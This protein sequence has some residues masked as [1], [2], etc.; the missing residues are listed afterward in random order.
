MTKPTRP[1]TLRLS[2]T[3]HDKY[4]WLSFSG[5]LSDDMTAP[6]RRRF[7][8][9]LWL[10]AWPAPLRVVIS[11]D[12]SGSWD[13]AEDWAGTWSVLR[14]DLELRFTGREVPRGR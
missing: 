6:R 9:L 5:L 10:L 13:W 11:A 4:L 14:G 7:L 2:T 1:L 3:G 8:R 12:E